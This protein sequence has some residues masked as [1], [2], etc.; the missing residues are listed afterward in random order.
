MNLPTLTKG[1]KAIPIP[2]RVLI[3]NTIKHLIKPHCDTN[4]ERLHSYRV[5]YTPNNA[6]I[7]SGVTQSIRVKACNCIDALKRAAYV[8]GQSVEHAE[9]IDSI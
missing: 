4:I 6:T 8:L 7:D 9:R 2:R 5:M 3:D 1:G